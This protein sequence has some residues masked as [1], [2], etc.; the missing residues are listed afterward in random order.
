MSKI[1]VAVGV[2]AVV[3]GG[4]VYYY[5]G[6]GEPK[7]PATQAALPSPPAPTARPPEVPPATPAVQFPIDPPPG[8]ESNATAPADANA[9]VEAALVDLLGRPAALLHLQFDNFA[10]RFVATVDNL[11]RE[12]A[13]PSRWPINPTPGKFTVEPAGG[14]E[15]ISAANAVRYAAL[16]ALVE[17]VDTRRAV[18]VYVRLY[19]H[20]QGAYEALGFPGR[21]FN[22][23]LV[24]VIDH[25]LATPEPV[26]T[27]TVRLTEV[28]GPYQPVQPWKHYEFVDDAVEARSAGQK[29]LTRV[30]ADHQQRLKAKLTAVRALITAGA[31][32][33]NTA[34]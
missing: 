29:I 22:D 28:K 12:Q 6:P 13:P 15:R 7:P 32:T 2:A 34:R 14:T 21:H 4:L 8:A 9:V 27:Q 3:V 33:P 25:L 16:V 5:V 31:R 18:D 26:A 10:Q 1:L 11:P 30:G 19:P 24:Q 17:Q 23:R 20:F